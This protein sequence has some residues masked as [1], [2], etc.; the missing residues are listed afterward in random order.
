MELLII[1]LA[2][3][4]GG[5]L[6]FKLIKKLIVAAIS[7]V[8]LIA[9]IFGVLGGVI[10]Y[11][12]HSIANQEDFVLQVELQ[13][14]S[15]Q[16]AGFSLPFENGSGDFNNL[17]EIR[18]QDEKNKSMRTVVFDR[19]SFNTLIEE[20]EFAMDSFSL[21]EDYNT[22]ISGSDYNEILN[23]QEPIEVFV[24]KLYANY[25][26][27]ENIKED[28]IEQA[29]TQIRDEISSLG[30]DDE[31]DFIF[32]LGFASLIN[33]RDAYLELFLLY[34]EDKIIIKPESISMKFISY[35]PTDFITDIFREE[36][37]QE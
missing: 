6:I 3:I 22:T 1:G 18:E 33:N 24:D 15:N 5:L 13:E 17:G 27:P 10:F 7:F 19:E 36:N 11:D 12:I 14:N 32:A 25:S 28:A 30:I 35:I 23:S 31:R 4:V 21:L 29:E 2:I 8:V 16:Q 9:L 20:R 34:K 37:S 26:M